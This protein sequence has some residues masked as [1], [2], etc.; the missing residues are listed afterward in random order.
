[1]VIDMG[2]TDYFDS[3]FRE[4]AS[5]RPQGKGRMKRREVPDIEFSRRAMLFCPQSAAYEASFTCKSY[6]IEMFPEVLCRSFVTG[7]LSSC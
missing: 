3:D 6:Y 5:I 1:M 7:I 4:Y 2:I